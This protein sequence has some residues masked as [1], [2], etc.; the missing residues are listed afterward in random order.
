MELSTETGVIGKH[1]K[2]AAS[3]V[4]SQIGSTLPKYLSRLKLESVSINK[5]SF[6]F[7]VSFL[8]YYFVK[9][10]LFAAG[11]TLYSYI[12]E[13]SVVWLSSMM[14][15]FSIFFD[16]IL[17]P[18]ITCCPLFFFEVLLQTKIVSFIKYGLP[19]AQNSSISL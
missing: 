5:F 17:K 2:C 15:F 3:E 18:Y 4:V 13:F 19:C 7:N 11:I 8:K 12:E 9:T 14:P 1:I 6:L 10:N 16:I